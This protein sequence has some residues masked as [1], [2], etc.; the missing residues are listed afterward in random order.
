MQ[1]EQALY[2][3]II[4]REVDNSDSVIEP[5]ETHKSLEDMGQALVDELKDLNLRGATPYVC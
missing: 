1:E 5:V 4:V 2:N 3:H